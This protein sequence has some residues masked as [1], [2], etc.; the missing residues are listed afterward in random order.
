MFLSSVLLKD[1]QMIF[2]ILVFF[3][4]NTVLQLVIIIIQNCKILI[5]VDIEKYYIIIY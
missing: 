5:L 4:L 2:V 1:F 3:I